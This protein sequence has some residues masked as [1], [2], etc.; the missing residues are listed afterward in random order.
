MKQ[1]RGCLIAF[2]ALVLA[3]AAMQPRSAI[4]AAY[5]AETGSDATYRLVC[6]TDASMAID[7]VVDSS[8][9]YNPVLARKSSSTSQLFTLTSGSNGAV[10]IVSVAYP[11]LALTAVGQES[12]AKVTAASLGSTNQ[13]WQ[14]DDLGGGILHVQLDTSF[15]LLD[16]SGSAAKAGAGCVLSQASD[17]GT[18]YWMLQRIEGV[19]TANASQQSR[20]VVC[21]GDSFLAGFA[22]EGQQANWGSIVGNSIGFATYRYHDGGSGFSAQGQKGNTF[23]RLADTA[24]REHPTASLV[25]VGGGYNDHMARFSPNVLRAASAQFAQRITSYWPDAEVFVFVNLWGN[26]KNTRLDNAHNE[27]ADSR[28]EAIRAGLESVGNAHIHVVTD[29]WTWIYAGEGLVGR[30]NIHPLTAGQAVIAQHMLDAIASECPQI[31]GA[32]GGSETGFGGTSGGAQGSGTSASASTSTSATDSPALPAD[33]VTVTLD[34]SGMADI[35]SFAYVDGRAVP[36][37]ADSSG[38]ATVR[39]TDRNA[40]IITVYAC[41]ETSSDVHEAYPT[42]MRV[43]YFAYDSFQRRY[44]AQRIFALDDVLK[45]AGL[46]GEVTG[47][48]EMGMIIGIPKDTKTVLVGAGV[49]FGGKR[50]NLEECGTVVAFDSTLAGAD[51]TQENAKYRD[52]VYRRGSTDSVFAV[53]NGLVEYASVLTDFTGTQSKEGIA[54]RPYL[55]LKADDGE[56][57]TI[58]GGTVHRSI[59]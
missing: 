41:S 21:I 40:K 50:W 58:Y 12:G 13:S 32:A 37:S 57:L 56:L 4:A 35:G 5:D 29:C 17:T 52:A 43:W 51:V 33:G 25:L 54:M 22:L 18:Q 14:L 24:H 7:L 39:I 27:A 30:D 47:N 48:R 28:A 6:A 9:A 16:L 15:L 46:S 8:G 26:G 49:A 34:V 55:I 45:Y 36:M 2:A 53:E 1:L 11:G 44:R 59:G 38:I 19:A 23:I 10:S 3:L 31:T 20:D 42:H